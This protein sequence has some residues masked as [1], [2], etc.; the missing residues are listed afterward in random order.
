MS[1]YYEDLKL[2]PEAS[3]VEIQN[4]IDTLYNQWRQAVTHPDPAVTDEANRNLRVLEQMRATL[5]VPDRRA[6]YD[7][8]LGLGG[9]GGLADPTAV[10]Q[11][12][13]PPRPKTAAQPADIAPEALWDCPK[14]K[15]R[16]PEWTQYCL[17]CGSVLVRRCPECNQMKSLVKTGVCG[18]CGMPYQDAERRGKLKSYMKAIDDSISAHQ[19]V[20]MELNSALLPP[21]MFSGELLALALLALLAGP[22]IFL[23]YDAALGLILILIAGILLA[24]TWIIYRKKS[25]AITQANGA[26]EAEMAAERNTLGELAQSRQEAMD[27]YTALDRR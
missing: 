25:E 1:N 10:I 24:V 9:A 18:N 15:T 26:L 8:G 16:N 2:T 22:A 14:C 20:L 17:K 5:S 27:A 12:M 6:I 13:T 21:A 19:Q 7:A 11:R 23:T 4:A 3:L